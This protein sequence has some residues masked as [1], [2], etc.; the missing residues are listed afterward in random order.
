VAKSKGGKDDIEN[1]KVACRTCNTKKSNKPVEVFESEYD[2][3]FKKMLNDV[4]ADLRTRADLAVWRLSLD[5]K[6]SFKKWVAY[7][8]KHG[9]GDY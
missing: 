4:C 5:H 2:L 1:L 9:L 6:G 8:K 3:K 7:Q